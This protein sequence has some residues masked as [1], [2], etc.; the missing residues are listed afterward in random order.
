MLLTIYNITLCSV[1]DGL[2]GVLLTGRGEANKKTF[3]KDL[4]KESK[5]QKKVDRKSVV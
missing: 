1:K 3:L 5:G 2:V 4:N